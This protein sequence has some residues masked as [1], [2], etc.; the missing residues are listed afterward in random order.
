MF[1][2]TIKSN[3]LDT[4]GHLIVNVVYSNGS[5][6]IPESYSLNSPDQI[7][8]ILVN[9]LNQ[10]NNIQTYLDKPMTGTFTPSQ[11]AP[12]PTP[13]PTDLATQKFIQDLNVLRQLQRAV[14][15]GIKKSTDNDIVSQIALVQSEFLSDYLDLL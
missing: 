6:N 11:P 9:R 2:A 12:T 14:T 1:T 15:L 8:G 10:L 3:D 5:Q 4:Q 13:S 7:H